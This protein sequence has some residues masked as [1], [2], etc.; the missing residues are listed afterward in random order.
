MIIEPDQTDPT[1]A[2][3]AGFLTSLWAM[4]IVVECH[5]A[6]QEGPITLTELAE[7]VDRTD[8][9]PAIEDAAAFAELIDDADLGHYLDAL[10]ADS[11][12]LADLDIEELLARLTGMVPH[13]GV[14]LAMVDLHLPEPAVAYLQARL[15]TR[16]WTP[17]DEQLRIGRT[18][19]L[20][21]IDLA[22]GTSVED[23]W[24]ELERY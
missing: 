24:Q 5:R 19:V 9:A 7:L 23:G 12:N 14:A 20:D 4:K 18:F 6:A 10:S 15:D 16:G 8:P 21:W 11:R 17:D 1:T 22:H 13:P 2:R 3:L